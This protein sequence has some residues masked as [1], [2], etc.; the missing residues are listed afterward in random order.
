MSKSE[1]RTEELLI[2][3]YNDPLIP[4][5]K[6]CADYFRLTADKFMR[7]VS[8][9]E[10]RLPIVRMYDD[11]QKAAKAVRVQDLASY[12]DTRIDLAL[13]EFKTLYE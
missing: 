6:V 4:V 3:K 5:E 7:K 12:L 11:S 9:G 2:S 1:T 10:I 8:A 13:K